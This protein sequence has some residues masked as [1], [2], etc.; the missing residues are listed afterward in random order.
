MI[1]KKPKYI[2][3]ILALFCA[4]VF[5]PYGAS[6]DDKNQLIKAISVYKL[7]NY[8]GFSNDSIEPEFCYTS[9][10]KFNLAL[11]KINRANREMKRFSD[12]EIKKYPECNIIYFDDGTKVNLMKYVKNNQSELLISDRKNFVKNYDGIIELAENK[13]KI[14]FILNLKKAK[15]VGINISSKLI[16]SA[17]KI[18]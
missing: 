10:D 9:D 2:F 7:L 16:E 4:L 11:K 15:R 14:G 18:Y 12:Y 1:N 6:A 5:L 13:G 17:Q 8:V 3:S